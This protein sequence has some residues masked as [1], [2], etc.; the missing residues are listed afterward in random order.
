MITV[1]LIDNFDSFT[2]NLAHLIAAQGVKV[3]V[4]A[5]NS[6]SI[7]TLIERKRVDALVISPGPGNPDRDPNGVCQ[8]LGSYWG[9]I[10]VLG[11]CLGMQIIAHNFG[12]KIRRLPEPCHG[13]Q[14]P[15]YHNNSGIFAR[16]PQAIM[17]AQYHSLCVDPASLPPQLEITAKD[18][19]GITMAI[20]HPGLSLFGLQFHPESFLSEYGSEMLRNFLST[21]PNKSK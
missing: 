19:N 17:V 15:I 13:I 11:V 8:L 18:C 7:L 4:E 2:H 1:L 14:T 10:P 3:L 5:N 20:A 12:A 6:E 9:R 21:L 16:I